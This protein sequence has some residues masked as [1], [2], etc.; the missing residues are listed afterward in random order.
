MA[1]D[2]TGSLGGAAEGGNEL[3][4][5]PFRKREPLGVPYLV[6]VDMEADGHPL[7]RHHGQHGFLTRDDWRITGVALLSVAESLTD[8]HSAAFRQTLVFEPEANQ[9]LDERLIHSGV[10][11]S[12]GEQTPQT[13][14]LKL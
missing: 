1:R 5:V 11:L 2:A 6:A 9:F 10:Q 13:R 7:Q 14:G 12:R 4:V 8:G 3:T